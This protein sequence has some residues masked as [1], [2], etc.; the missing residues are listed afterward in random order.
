MSAA[1]ERRY[2]AALDWYPKGWRDE[3][4]EAMLGTL[5]DEAE[6]TGREKPRL[7]DLLN[8]A[9]HGIAEGLRRIPARMPSAMRDRVAAISL[10]TGFAFALVFFVAGE[11]APWATN[12]PWNGWAI[13]WRP[14]NQE[15]PGFGPFASAGVILYGLWFAGFGLAL[16]GFARTA[17]FTLFATLPVSLMLVELSADRMVAMRPSNEMLIMLSFLALFAMVGRPTRRG[18]KRRGA[19]WLVVAALSAA[20][21]PAALTAQLVIGRSSASHWE[22]IA[23]LDPWGGW[24][25]IN[26]PGIF[27]A[28]SAAIALLA[29]ARGDRSWASAFGLSAI[30]WFT[31]CVAIVIGSGS[32][33]SF[34]VSVVLVVVA[35]VATG[36][37]VLRAR[38]YRI[39]LQRTDDTVAAASVP[40]AS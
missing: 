20:I 24:F 8:L 31:A 18:Q 23:R 14:M 30:P 21:V 37:L 6:A 3:N 32:A 39:V 13:D 15:V 5:L 12:G 22:V 16:V 34:V 19:K 4:G 35:V 28:V 10:G 2:R 27:F 1:L 40:P 9:L 25:E 17:S 38:G 29:L 7:G 36:N 26:Q 11:W 33:W